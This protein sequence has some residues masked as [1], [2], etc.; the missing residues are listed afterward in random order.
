MIT[1]RA[2]YPVSPSQFSLPL[3]PI[4]TTG[5]PA[6]SR[7][8]HYNTPRNRYAITKLNAR[9]DGSRSHDPRHSPTLPF[10]RTRAYTEGIRRLASSPS[11]ERSL[12]TGLRRHAVCAPARLVALIGLS[13]SLS[14][15][16]HTRIHVH[17]HVPQQPERKRRAFFI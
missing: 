10:S 11:G 3:K 1:I 13:L 2:S 8:P 6:E 12:H 16:H 9:C 15:Q 14:S 5:Q 4:N 17:V 7:Y